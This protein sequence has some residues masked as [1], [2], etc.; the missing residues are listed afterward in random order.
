VVSATDQ[1]GRYSRFSRPEA[2][3]SSHSVCSHLLTPVP[4]WLFLY[5]EDGGDMFLRNVDLHN[6]YTAPNRIGRHFSASNIRYVKEQNSL[7]FK[8]LQWT[9]VSSVLQNGTQTRGHGECK[10][11][12]HLKISTMTL[13]PH[14]E[15]LC[16]GV[17]DDKTY[18]EAAV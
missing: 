16:Q 1:H 4:R 8:L 2:Y 14:C 12:Q 7:R 10:N 17:G 15:N 13:V 9:G 3:T 5:P 18:P 6:I 11:P